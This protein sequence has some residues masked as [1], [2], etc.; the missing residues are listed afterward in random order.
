[1]RTFR[2]GG[3]AAGC[4]SPV[5]KTA[6]ILPSFFSLWVPFAFIY[7][8][9]GGPLSFFFVCALSSFWYHFPLGPLSLFIWVPSPFS[10]GSPLPSFQTPFP[11]DSRSDI[12]PLIFGTEDKR[13]P[14]LG[15]GGGGG[16]WEVKPRL[17]TGQKRLFF[18]VCL[19]NFPPSPFFLPPL[20]RHPRNDN[21]KNLMPE[22]FVCLYKIICAH[23]RV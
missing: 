11:F 18:P 20:R 21:K 23:F 7:F 1:M 17:E 22:K 4:F 8:S 13:P 6:S 3:V 19:A 16:I 12:P 5:Y 10:F 14:G 15:G 2:S 9:L